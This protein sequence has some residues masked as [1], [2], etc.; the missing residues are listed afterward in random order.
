LRCRRARASRS[1][2]LLSVFYPR[3]QA[4]VCVWRRRPS[5]GA[6]LVSATQPSSHQTRTPHPP[7]ARGGD[8]VELRSRNGDT[9]KA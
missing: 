7:R 8:V 6:W 5:V 4:C 3:S 9:E 1:S 2:L